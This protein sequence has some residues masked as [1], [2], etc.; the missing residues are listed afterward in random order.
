MEVYSPLRTLEGQEYGI[1]YWY[2]LFNPR[3]LLCLAM[4]TEYVHERCKSFLSLCMHKGI[5]IFCGMPLLRLL[6]LTVLLLFECRLVELVL[7][8]FL[9]LLAVEFGMVGD[10]L[11]LVGFR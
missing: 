1:K 2:E 10:L 9:G 7:M 4:L 8:L 3:Q 5:F 6:G 11:L